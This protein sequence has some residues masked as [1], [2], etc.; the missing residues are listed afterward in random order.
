MYVFWCVSIIL[1]GG[2]A[3]QWQPRSQ[4]QQQQQTLSTHTFTILQK[5]I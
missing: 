1:L 4:Q 5:Y 2:F 3:F